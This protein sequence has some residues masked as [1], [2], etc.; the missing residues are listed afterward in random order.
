[1][2]GG[3]T[4]ALNPATREQ[5]GLRTLVEV[6]PALQALGY[7]PEPALRMALRDLGYDPNVLLIRA[8]QPAAPAGLPAGPEGGAMSSGEQIAAQGGP[9]LPAELQARGG[10]AL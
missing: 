6:V 2:E 1:M 7:D 5:Q 8:E 10:I 9:G 3:S 4:R